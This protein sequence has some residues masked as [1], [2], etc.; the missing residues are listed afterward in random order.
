MRPTATELG[1]DD[2]DDFEIDDNLV[3]SGSDIDEDD[4]SEE[5]EDDAEEYGEAGEESEDEFTKG[6]LTES[7]SKNIL[8]HPLQRKG[9]RR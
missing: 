9:S 6:L 7:E 4:L 5:E 1:F 8:F 3:A 2:E